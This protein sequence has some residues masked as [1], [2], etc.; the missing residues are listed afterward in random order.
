MF[1]RRISQMK[2]RLLLNE[3]LCRYCTQVQLF[4]WKYIHLYLYKCL[5][6]LIE[7]SDFVYNVWLFSS[8]NSLFYDFTVLHPSGEKETPPF[9][10]GTVKWRVCLLC[11]LEFHSTHFSD[12]G[13][14][15]KHSLTLINIFGF[16]LSA[17]KLMGWRRKWNVIYAYMFYVPCACFFVMSNHQVT[18]TMH[19]LVKKETVW[20]PVYTALLK[21]WHT[22][23]WLHRKPDCRM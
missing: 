6:C 4:V 13:I 22:A 20:L 21:F 7:L 16:S 14:P 17:E 8:N 9:M 11:Q 2:L 10:A 18:T 3:Q 5:F 19:Q 23:A 12:D 1:W 15:S